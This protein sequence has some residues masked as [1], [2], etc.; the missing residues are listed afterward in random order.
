MRRNPGRRPPIRIVTGAEHFPPRDNELPLCITDDYEVG[1][2][3]A[4]ALLELIATDGQCAPIQK[5]V[6]C[7]IR[8]SQE[9][10]A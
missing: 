7:R 6:P 5:T 10:K 3:A 8:Y 4:L 2:S 1:R 9:E